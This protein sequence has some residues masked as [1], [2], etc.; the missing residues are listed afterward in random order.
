MEFTTNGAAAPDAGAPAGNGPLTFHQAVDALAKRRQSDE[1]AEGT[2]PADQAQHDA[3]PQR[4]QDGAR[5]HTESAH[6]EHDAAPD[7]AQPSGETHETDEPAEAPPID[8]PASWTKDEKERF[9]ALPRETQDY[10]AERE[11][12]RDAEL[13]RG[14]NE[15]AEARKALA[16]EHQ[17][18]LAAR[19]R[20]ERA[21]PELLHVLH[22]HAA[23]EFADIR[24]Q[25][26][27]RRLAEQD[28][29]RFAR[30][31]AAQMHTAQV[32]Q[33]AESAR[34]RQ[35]HGLAQ[36]FNAWAGEQDAKFRAQFREFSE[37]EKSEK[38]RATIS[39]YLT[40]VAEVTSEQLAEL[41]NMPL[42][43]D[44][45][46]QRVV[47]DAAR[48]HAAQEKAKSATAAPKPPVQRPGTA[49]VK[50]TSQ[51]A[52]IKALEDK[53]AAATTTREQIAAAAALRA[54]KRA[55]A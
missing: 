9:K 40:E 24:T 36:A 49:P 35:A 32:A 7:D 50:A 52:T 8:P 28:P 48:F 51:D 20:Y 54:A 37:P 43:R 41:W 21:L 22:T 46:M 47:Y 19:Q 13:R 33:E 2:A 29:G 10:I 6:S 4:G 27:V 25:D 5:A 55:A 26:D 45:R 16:A 1:S 39:R 38:A 17:A 12:A 3:S 53:L 31:Q 42:F 44:A 15:V 34:A 23:G 18:I 14:Q 11:R 30:F